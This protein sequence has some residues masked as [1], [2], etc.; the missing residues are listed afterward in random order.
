MLVES[1][2]AVSIH[3]FTGGYLESLDTFKSFP[4]QVKARRKSPSRHPY[5]FLFLFEAIV[6]CAND[7]TTSDSVKVRDIWCR[8]GFHRRLHIP[9]ARV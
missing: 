4:A 3:F 8:S 7:G 6:G 2:S 5:S 1:N 9:A